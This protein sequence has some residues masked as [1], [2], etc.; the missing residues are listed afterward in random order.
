MILEDRIQRGFATVLAIRLSGQIF[1]YGGMISRI[2]FARAE[3][4][5]T[6]FR[7]SSQSG[8]AIFNIANPALQ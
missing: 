7:I 5:R 1:D 2:D 6:P 3:E 8:K 4:P